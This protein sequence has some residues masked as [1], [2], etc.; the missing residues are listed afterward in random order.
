MWGGVFYLLTIVVFLFK[1]MFS[2][3]LGEFRSRKVGKFFILMGEDRG[4]GSYKHGRVCC[5]YVT[6]HC[7]HVDVF[8]GVS[9]P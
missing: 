1:N 5:L 6:S 3:F 7:S 2:A 9:N 4:G 8:V